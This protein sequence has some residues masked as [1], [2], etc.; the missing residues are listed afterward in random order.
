M[1]S[2]WTPLHE[3][4]I[5]LAIENQALVLTLGFDV[6][7]NSDCQ[8][9]DRALGFSRCGSSRDRVDLLADADLTGVSEMGRDRSPLRVGQFG[10]AGAPFLPCNGF[11]SS[12]PTDTSGLSD[13]LSEGRECSEL[14]SCDRGRP[15]PEPSHLDGR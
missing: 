7:E 1:G 9:I 12:Q 4:G 3:A 8:G 15:P 10:S 6:L 5:V 2:T 13:R 11:R 14:L